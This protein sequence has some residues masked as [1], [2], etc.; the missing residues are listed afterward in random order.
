MSRQRRTLEFKLEVVQHFI[1]TSDGQ[2][3]TGARFGID[4]SHVRNWANLYKLHGLDGLRTSRRTYTPKEKESILLYR[5]KHHMSFRQVAE[6]F[7]IHAA[8]LIVK[9]DKNYNLYGFDGL[10]RKKRQKKMKKPQ[11]KF[12]PLKA[13]KDK[14]QEELLEELAYLRT[15]NAYLKKRKAL[16]QK[17]KEQEKVE[18]QR[19]QGSYLN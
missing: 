1:S 19:L 8:N 4:E 11:Q 17:Q 12:K 9:W 16:I 3:R 18:Q 2:K 14:T 6:H 15:E 13:D 5:I 10:K 7:N